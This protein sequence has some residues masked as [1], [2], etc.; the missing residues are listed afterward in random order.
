MKKTL[1]AIA[2]FALFGTAA[3]TAAEESQFPELEGYAADLL[4]EPPE[5]FRWTLVWHDE[6]DGTDL[7]PAHWEALESP[8]HEGIW[9]RD[10]FELTGDGILKM[11]VFQRENGDYIDGCIRTRGKFEKAKGYFVARMKMPTQVGHWPAFWL[12]NSCE[13]SVGNGRADGAE[14]VIMEKPFIDDHF[15]F[16]I[17]WDGYWE[18]H[19]LCSRLTRFDSI[20]EGFHTFALWWGDDAY[21][22]FVDGTPMW[23][24]TA[25]GICTEPLYIKFSDEVWEHKAG[26]IREAKLPDE[27]LIDYVRVYDLVPVDAEAASK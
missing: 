9:S 12:M 13:T 16:A 18:N 11:K 15:D 8:R 7:D 3:F 1:L 21:R 26:D 17:H 24:T 23:E 19:Q 14:I 2:C 27:T 25:D 6:F 5:G 22:F 20:R 4:P 10:G